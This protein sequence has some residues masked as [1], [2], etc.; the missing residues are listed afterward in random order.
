[1]NLMPRETLRKTL[2][3][4]VMIAVVAGA[5]IARLTGGWSRWPVDSLLAFW[6]TFGGHWVELWFLNGVRPRIPAAGGVQKIARLAVWFV[7]GA[8]LGFGITLTAR[9]FGIGASW[10]SWWK[11]GILFIGVELIVH[12]FLLMRGQSGFFRDRTTAVL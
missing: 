10:S 8:L 1:M 5:V 9:V 2:T 3:R 11:F 6:I 7:G 12:L 4:T